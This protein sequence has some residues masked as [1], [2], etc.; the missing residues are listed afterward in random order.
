[1]KRIY[2]AVLILVIFPAFLL[3]SCA[4]SKMQ[5]LY[6]GESLPTSE[7][8]RLHRFDGGRRDQSSNQCFLKIRIRELDGKTLTRSS[9]TLEFLPG[10]HSVA[11]DFQY[12]SEGVSPISTSTIHFD[13]EAGGE[14]IFGCNLNTYSRQWSVWVVDSFTGKNVRYR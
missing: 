3:S 12:L 10:S 13:A 1:M 8:A 14:Y 7:T 4:S 11:V 9:D 5:R 6:S 2:Y